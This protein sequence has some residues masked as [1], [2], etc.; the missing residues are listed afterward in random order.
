[1]VRPHAA[2]RLTPEADEGLASFLEKREPN[3]YPAEGKG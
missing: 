2:K 3:W 1:M